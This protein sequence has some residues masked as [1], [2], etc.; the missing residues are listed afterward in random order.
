[1]RKQWR[2]LKAK[3]TGVEPCS[4]TSASGHE[5]DVVG[6]LGTTTQLRTLFAKCSGCG[7]I[8]SIDQWS[9]GW[10]VEPEGL[11]KSL[12]QEKDHE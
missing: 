5:F 12:N 8:A 7:M 10:T 6:R 9:M 1:M 2:K 4:Y 11:P 3:I